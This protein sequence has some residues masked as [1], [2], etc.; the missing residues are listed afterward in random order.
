MISPMAS[1]EEKKIRQP[2]AACI[3]GKTLFMGLSTLH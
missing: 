2:L 1:E 3:L